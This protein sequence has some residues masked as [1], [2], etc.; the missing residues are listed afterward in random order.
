MQ[1]NEN[2][3]SFNEGSLKV[4]QTKVTNLSFLV[5]SLRAMK[6]WKMIQGWEGGCWQ[7]LLFVEKTD[8]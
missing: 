4:N 7:K 8:E 3:F 6:Y 2:L 5:A 1:I